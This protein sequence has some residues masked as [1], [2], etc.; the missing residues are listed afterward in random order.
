V[1]QTGFVRVGEEVRI[2]KYTGESISVLEMFRTFYEKHK[3]EAELR[4]QLNAP[5]AIRARVDLEQ[6]LRM[7]LGEK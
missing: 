2:E 7:V 5:I 6:E 1:I 4:R 3:S